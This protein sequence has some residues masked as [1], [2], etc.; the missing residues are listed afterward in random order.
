MFISWAM[1]LLFL[2][3]GVGLVSSWLGD[4]GGMTL[5][6]L[7][8]WLLVGRLVRFDCGCFWSVDYCCSAR[9]GIV[10]GILLRVNH[11]PEI[12]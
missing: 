10:I 3:G 2:G 12:M 6:S 4:S 7:A 9:L 8:G 11:L 5:P 1:G